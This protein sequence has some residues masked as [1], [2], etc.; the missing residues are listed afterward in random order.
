MQR[1]DKEEAASKIRQ[2]SRSELVLARRSLGSYIIDARARLRA[3]QL[4]SPEM[5]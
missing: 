2:N 5:C 3:G 4:S 1:D